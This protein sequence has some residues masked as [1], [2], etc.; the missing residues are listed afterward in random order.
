MITMLRAGAILIAALALVSIIGPGWAAENQ[1]ICN[2]PADL[3]LGLEDYQSALILHRQVV[4]SHP[5]DALAHY[6]LGFVY[7]IIGCLTEE[8]R[9]YRSAAALGLNQ[10]DLFLNLGLAYYE[11]QQWQAAATAFEHA[12][13]LSPNQAQAHLNLALAYEREHRLSDALREITASRHLAPENIDAINTNAIIC[14]EMGNTVCAHDLWAGLV[15]TVPEYAPAQANLAILTGSWAE[16]RSSDSFAI[17]DN[18]QVR[19]ER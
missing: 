2:G 8:I 6:H 12:V 4:R 1:Q 19:G 11:R 9:E 3:A 13:R 17:S 5:R 7:G 14:A 15:R 10:W 18:S 16:N